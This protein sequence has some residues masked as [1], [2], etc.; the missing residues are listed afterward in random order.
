MQGSA[1]LVL[2]AF[3]VPSLSVDLAEI[4]RWYLAARQKQKAGKN[5]ANGGG[6]LSRRA[7]I[8][9]N[10]PGMIKKAART[11]QDCRHW[12]GTRVEGSAP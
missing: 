12:I 3:A 11:G 7:A 6:Q 8:S 4:R 9:I 2:L 5:K 10:P 1:T